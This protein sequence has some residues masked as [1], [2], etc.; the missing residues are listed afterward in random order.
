[1]PVEKEEK[2]LLSFYEIWIVTEL[3]NVTVFKMINRKKRPFFNGQNNVI[4][5]VLYAGAA[6]F[7]KSSAAFLLRQ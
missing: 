1:M 5:I 7:Q 2:K 3:E 4:R 6:A